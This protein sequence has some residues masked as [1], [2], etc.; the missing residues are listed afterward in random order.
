MTARATKLLAHLSFWLATLVMIVMGWTLYY[1]TANEIKS[2]Q[3]I[4]HRQDVLRTVA[5]INEEFSRAESAQRGFLLSGRDVFLK[6]T[7]DRFLFDLE[8][9][10]LAT[11]SPAVK[12]TPV[13]VMLREGVVFGKVGW[14]VLTT[15]SINFI[16]ILANTR[17]FR[18][19]HRPPSAVNR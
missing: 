8:F 9:L 19:V 18:P 17:R 1:A 14:R 13:P 11:K 12:I 7:I 2:S 4:S 15:E 6:T 16:K 3:W 5:E 10:V